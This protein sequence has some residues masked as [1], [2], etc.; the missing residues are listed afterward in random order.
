MERDKKNTF[1]ETQYAAKT[2]QS[3][4]KRARGRGR[5]EN[6]LSNRRG[7]VP[8]AR[9]RLEVFS[10]REL[11]QRESPQTSWLEIGGDSRASPH[12]PRLQRCPPASPRFPG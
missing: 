2:P 9:E 6:A 11:P 5:A 10:N 7:E 8:R 4:E 1:K 12:P 3:D